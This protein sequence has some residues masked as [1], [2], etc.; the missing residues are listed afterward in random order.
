[1][2]SLLWWLMVIAIVVIVF[3]EV[4]GWCQLVP[5]R[6]VVHCSA[7]E[8]ERLTVDQ[9]LARV[10]DDRYREDV[11]KAVTERKIT[12]DCIGLVLVQ[13]NVD[14]HQLVVWVG[15]GALATSW[16]VLEQ[17]AFSRGKPVAFCEIE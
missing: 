15:P 6:K 16:P 9:L 10:W 2:N 11:R 1:M 8:L 17:M 12:L 3:W 13:D 5:P 14:E 4:R 7:G